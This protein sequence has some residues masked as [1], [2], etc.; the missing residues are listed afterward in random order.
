[1][2]SKFAISESLSGSPYDFNV[3]PDAPDSRDR[4]YNPPLISLRRRL[5]PWS[6]GDAKWWSAA[7]VRDQGREGSCVG[8]AMAA[9]IDHLR[10]RT[11]V[12]DDDHPEAWTLEAPWVS[13][14][15]LYETARFHDEWAG[16][17]YSGSSLR[18]GLKGFFYNGVCSMQEEDAFGLGWAGPNP[19]PW[20]MTKE[21]A[22]KARAIQLGAYYRVCP[23]LPD[24]HAA[25]NEARVLVASSYVHDGWMRPDEDGTIPFS[26]VVVQ[27]ERPLEKM[28]AFAV[29]GYNDNGF[30]IQNSWGRDWGDNGR[31]LWT[32]PDWAATFCDA[33]VMRLAVLPPK[34]TGC[35][36]GRLRAYS[37]FVNRAET[38]FL[39]KPQ[40][41]FSAPSR[42]DVL[43]HMLP[44]RDGALDEY[45][46]YNVN[47]R[48]LT[49][50]FRLIRDRPNEEESA[51]TKNASR[52]DAFRYRHV[53][54]YFL[55][56]WP[57]ES[58]LA[59]QL[60][61]ISPV[62]REH[63]VYPL[64]FVWESALF[65]ELA[66][67]VRRTIEDV[68]QHSLN[69]SD[70]RRNVRDRLIEERL[71][72]P[73]NRM[74]REL[75]CGARRMFVRDRPDPDTRR[76]AGG[77]VPEEEAGGFNAASCLNALFAALEDRYRKGTISFHIAA[78]GFGAQVLLECL[79]NHDRF[80][81]CPVFSSG[82]LIS[83]LVAVDRARRDLFEA[84]LGDKDGRPGRRRRS[85]EFIVEQLDL[86]LLSDLAL[87]LDRFSDDYGG[88]WPELWTRVLAMGHKD[89][90][91][92]LE[93][94][95]LRQRV[96]PLLAIGR[97]ARGEIGRAGRNV[98]T[99]FT[100][101]NEDQADSSLHHDLSLNRE[102][103]STMLNRILDRP[104]GDGHYFG[105]P[106]RAVV[107]VD[108]D[109]NRHFK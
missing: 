97:N 12:E 109:G 21:L 82:S 106:S 7:R 73:A 3:I 51:P 59:A 83:P 67:L 47:Q 9:V 62:F 91:E 101:A 26:N 30:W 95:G 56:G 23:R 89:R 87:R 8:Y 18:G 64:F 37:P 63:G 45:G 71:A 72:I 43:G 40:R 79:A 90:S 32:Y 108:K 70:R 105:K 65:R 102:I 69:I 28:H 13:A 17:N 5:E 100:Q 98:S 1:M 29:V 61:E 31:A 94:D 25:L 6:D 20:Y 68:L 53:L 99:H 22:D 34:V 107:F 75:R 77:D 48:T 10:A 24:M 11:I 44:F 19:S 27:G 84:V 16:E 92:E 88:A 93:Q 86:Y 14:R 4:V 58:E 85:D 80:D 52:G 46:A 41:D 60:A 78:H 49:E 103:L 38:H 50:T 15:M 57:D 66:A 74:L 55:G 54:I 76:L 33:W 81:R 36:A 96:L 35:N 104:L 2:A 39:G 42:L